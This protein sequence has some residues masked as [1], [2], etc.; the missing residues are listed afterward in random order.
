MH[1]PGA[2]KQAQAAECAAKQGGASAFWAYSDAIFARTTSNGNGFPVENLVPLAVEQGLDE[3]A[4]RS[5]LESDATLARVKQDL[6]EG[7]AAGVS[8]TPGN[9]LVDNATGKVVMVNGA[10]PLED[11]RARVEAMLEEPAQ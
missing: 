10:R 4:F 6:E 1:N 8:G 11:L 7:A 5:C 9:F 2:M 3:A